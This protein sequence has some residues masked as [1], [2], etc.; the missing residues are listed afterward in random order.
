MDEQDAD[1][2]EEEIGDLLFVAV[3]LARRL[4]VDPEIALRRANMKFERRFRSMEDLASDQD[5]Q[6][7]SLSLNEQESLWQQVKRNEKP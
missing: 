5:I 7:S 1:H 3:N 4:K 6:F 2:I